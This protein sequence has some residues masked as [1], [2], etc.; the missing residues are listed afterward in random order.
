MD[1]IK[2]DLTFRRDH[3]RF[4]ALSRKDLGKKNDASQFNMTIDY[5]DIVDVNCI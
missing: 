1:I 2:G 5:L 4:E 3:L